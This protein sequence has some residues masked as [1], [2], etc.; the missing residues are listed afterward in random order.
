MHISRL[1]GLMIATA[2]GLPSL[3]AAESVAVVN[4]VAIDKKDVDQVVA[5]IVQNSN[6]QAQ[7]TPAMR[8]EIK[9][10]LINRQLIQEEARRRGLEKDADVVRRIDEARSDILQD[11]LFADIVKQNPVSDAQIK[12][13]YDEL[14]AKLNG[15][16]EVHA[17]QIVLATEADANAVLADLKKGKKFEALAQARSIDPQAKQN[18]GDMGWGNLSGMDQT[19]AG[20]LKPLGKGQYT[21][22]PFK[23][24]VGWFI[25]KVEE[26]RDAKAPAF[27]QVKPQLARQLQ[28]EQITKTVN[29]L[30]GKA[31]I[32]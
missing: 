20:I 29:E 27:D 3:A 26:V 19:L 1:A 15:Q 23:T 7:D 5:T 18:G 10:R 24:N 9:S 2:I 21:Q 28:E 22:K 32:Q 14:S 17:R 25:F 8:E 30:R 13:R 16:K 31:K 6:G 11:A 12:A 4:G